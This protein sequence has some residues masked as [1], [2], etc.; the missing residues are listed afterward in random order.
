M[1]QPPS[2]RRFWTRAHVRQ[3][4]QIVVAVGVGA[5]TGFLVAGLHWI[6]LGI[7]G[8][9]SRTDAAWVALLP[10]AGL[11][12]AA[13]IVRVHHPVSTETTEEYIRVFHDASGRMDIAGAPSRLLAAV[14]TIALGGSMGLEGPSIYLGAL[15]GERAERRF[16]ALIGERENRKVLL[17]AGAAAG[18]SAIFKAPVTGIIFALEVPYR[19]DFARHALIPAIFSAATSYLVFVALIG[20]T[21]L[22]PVASAPLRFDDLI[23]SLLIGVGCG[24]CAR[25][26]LFVFR[27]AADLSTRVPAAVAAAV[28]GIVT[29]AVGVAALAVF[30]LALPL[31][32]GY[33]GIL[34]ITRGVISSPWL[35]VVLLIMKIV[36]TSATAGGG[37][38]G[39][40]FF[41]SVMIGAATGAALGHVVSGPPS[42]FAVT[43]IAAFLGGVYKVPL[44]GVAFVAETTGAP[45][46]IIP[47]LLAS[48]V[49]YLLSGNESLSAHQR[50][51]S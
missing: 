9:I 5:A 42:L 1:E 51:R 8:P 44:A 38:V 43:G 10:I 26:F 37:G 32:P 12:S 7:W 29:A 46:Y 13:A 19:D 34:E 48:A 15:I 4:A 41:P 3:N 11:A 23:A 24:V 27:R 39:G 20:T 2:R 14:A 36:A 50:Y 16:H 30:H 28:G 45:A 6:V 47:G 35:L 18:I 25:V 21:P 49:G 22:F 33:N 31:G 40:L 17:V